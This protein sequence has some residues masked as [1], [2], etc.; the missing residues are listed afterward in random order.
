MRK[1]QRSAPWI[2][3]LAL[4]VLAVSITAAQAQDAGG[5][6]A[7][8]PPAE[9]NPQ[10]S[11][12]LDASEPVDF[13]HYAQPTFENSPAYGF[14]SPRVVMDPCDVI[15]ESIF[16]PAS[17]ENWKPLSLGT[18]F[19]EGWDQ[20]FAKA[21]EGT[22]GAP[23]QNWI[24]TPAGVFGRFLDT[25][26][27]YTNNMTNN[28]GLFLNPSYPFLPVKPS[29]TDGNQYAGYSVILLPLNARMELLLGTT[30]ISSN[31]SGSNGGYVG[32]W[33]DTGVEARFHL[34]EQRN[35]SLVT[36]LGERIPTGDSVN[37]NGINYVT[38]GAEFWWNFAPKWVLRGGSSINALT[39]RKS[40]TSVYVNQLSI[41]RYLTGKDAALK[42]L[43]VH[44]TAD[45]L[46]DIA[47]GANFIDDVYI[48]P[49]FRFA[50]GEEGNWGVLGGILIPVA[51]PQPYDYQMQFSLTR[52]F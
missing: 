4:V 41:G 39:G 43:V 11:L 12:R 45:V 48:N 31:K 33:G 26:F 13:E 24:G 49:G 9:A 18:F 7:G 16:G 20:P 22:N 17:K 34:I 21:P 50:L 51:G 14:V 46:S 47:G 37:G 23:K 2:G 15:H 1:T 25:G 19:S 44:V 30:F 28:H 35:F 40:A 32:N 6:P 5:A 38:P 10:A 8:E 52:S 27:I 29:T 42:N 36:F 3:I